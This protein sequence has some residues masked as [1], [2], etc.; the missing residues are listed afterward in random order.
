MSVNNLLNFFEESVVGGYSTTDDA[1]EI[2]D[3]SRLDTFPYSAVIW[4]IADKSP[5]EAYKNNRAEI[6]NITGKSGDVVDVERGQEGT[7]AITLE[8][9]RN[10]AIHVALTANIGGQINDSVDDAENHAQAVAQFTDADG[11]SYDKGAKGWSEDAAASAAQVDTVD[12]TGA[13]DDDSIRRVS[14][15]FVPDTLLRDTINGDPFLAYSYDSLKDGGEVNDIESTRL[16][17]RGME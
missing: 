1:I 14:G 12:F 13:E 11:T 6:I 17:I 8:A 4:D 9:G 2:S 5:I 16:L 7:S 10:Y 15:T 3:A